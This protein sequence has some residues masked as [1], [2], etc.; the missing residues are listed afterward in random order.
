MDGDKEKH[1]NIVK[2]GGGDASETGPV[3]DSAN[4]NNAL[5]TVTWTSDKEKD[6]EGD[7]EEKKPLNE[8]QA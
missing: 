4:I 2:N 7:N 1:P 3:S 5:T 8:E 6:K